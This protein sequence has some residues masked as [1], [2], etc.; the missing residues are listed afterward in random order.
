LLFQIRLLYRYATDPESD[1]RVLH[2]EFDLS[3]AG[4]GADFQPGDS[5]GVLPVNDSTLVEVG[6]YTLN[7]VYP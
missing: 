7:A 4:A 3:G 5:L 6:L 2:V 1:R